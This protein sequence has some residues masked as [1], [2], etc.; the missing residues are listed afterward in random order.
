MLQLRQ[1]FGR[2]IRGHA[3]RGV[4][5]ILDPRAADARRTAARSSRRCRRCPV[6]EEPR[7]VAEFFGAGAAVGRLNGRAHG[8]E[9][10]DP[11]AAAPRPGAED[12]RAAT[13]RAAAARA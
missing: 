11:A 13:A 10:E 1:G 4:V 2:L 9:S 3:D 8:E 7:A 12:A 6:A 5:A